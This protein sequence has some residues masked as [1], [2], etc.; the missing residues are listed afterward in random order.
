LHPHFVGRV[1][2]LERLQRLLAEAVAGRGRLATVAGEAAE[3]EFLVTGRA[4]AVRQRRAQRVIRVD[5]RVAVR[6]QDQRRAVRQLAYE[7]LQQRERR[8]VRPVGVVEQQQLRPAARPREQ[9]AR[10]GVGELE[11]RRRA[12][13][14]RPRRREA[15]AVAQLRHEVRDVA[16]AG[17]EVRAQLIEVVAGERVAHDQQ[18]GVERRRDRV[19][20]Q[21]APEHPAAAR[22][23][24][25]RGLGHQ[26]RGL[27][28][29]VQR[30]GHAVGRHRHRDPHE[31]VRVQVE[32]AVHG[33]SMAR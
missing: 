14:R 19:L 2:E 6:E 1:T 33:R 31:A 22:L 3:R 13:R 7:V 5:L 15:E 20:E 18:P 32:E 4:G 28:G 26:P 30:I 24:Q 9:E 12:V 23:R 16:R 25:P 8:T 27:L 17:A 21:L 11:A 10:D 29:V